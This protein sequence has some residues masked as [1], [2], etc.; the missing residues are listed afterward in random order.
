M[1][2]KLYDACLLRL[3]GIHKDYEMNS[4]YL[5]CSTCTPVYYIGLCHLI[6]WLIVQI[7]RI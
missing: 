5:V 3:C 2:M 6:A 1:L 4:S 7:N